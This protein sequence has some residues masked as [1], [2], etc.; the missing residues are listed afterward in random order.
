MAITNEFIAEVKEHFSV[1][2]PI[3]HKKMFGGAGFYCD[4]V[5]FAIADD[6]R[7]YLKGDDLSIPVYLEAGCAQFSYTDNSGQEM[8][9]KYFEP[10]ASA[11]SDPEEASRWGRLGLETAAR[12]A[13]KSG[14]K[15]KS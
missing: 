1:L 8:A 11:W 7:F 14:K 5:F 13:A 12:A 15:R 9:M 6:G 3:E 2:G 10:P 4:G